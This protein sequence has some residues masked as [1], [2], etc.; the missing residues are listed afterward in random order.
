MVT[1]INVNIFASKLN[2]CCE[3][4]TATIWNNYCW[5]IFITTLNNYCYYIFAAISDYYFGKYYFRQ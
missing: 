4:I 2:Y 3:W 5:C 1:T